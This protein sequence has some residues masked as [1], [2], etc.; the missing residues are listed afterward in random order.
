MRMKAAV[1]LATAAMTAATVTAGAQVVEVSAARPIEFGETFR[2]ES[3]ILGETRTINAFVPTV[4][5]DSIASPLPVLYM[6]DGGMREDFLHIAGLLQI[7]VSNGTMRPFILVGIENT[8][9]R[10]DLTG[11]TSNP[12]DS[13][14][15]PVVGQ[16]AAFRAFISD[17]LMPVVKSRFAVTD[18]AAIVGESLAG[19]FVVETCFADRD[20]FQTCIA[21][22]PSLWWNDGGLVRAT[23]DRSVPAPRMLYLATSDE[24]GIAELAR[25]LAD[26]I[27][28]RASPGSAVVYEPMP[29]ES[30]GSIYHPA[31]L[32]AFRRLFTPPGG[33]G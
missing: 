15:A 18:E 7:S 17:E 31:V 13:T 4:Y 29:D 32:R 26:I 6:P 10:R 21:V 3:R 24:A 22:D 5:G 23:R 25:E 30:H 33:G 19:L 28:S 27:G 16:S 9:R 8:A 20:L 2:I 14:I 12:E 11:P 1:V